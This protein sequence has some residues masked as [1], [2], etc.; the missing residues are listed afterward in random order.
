MPHKLN[1][2]ECLTKH[3][4]VVELREDGTCACCETNHGA[5]PRQSGRTL[6]KVRERHALITGHDFSVRFDECDVCFLLAYIYS[7]QDA[8]SKLSEIA[9]NI[10]LKYGIPWTDPRTG[11]VFQP[12]EKE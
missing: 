3:V 9:K 7:T 2:G 12:K 1:C 4:E 8:E 5:S 11:E 10:C 6:D